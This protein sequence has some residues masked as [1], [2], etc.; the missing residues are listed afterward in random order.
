MALNPERWLVR[1]QFMEIFVRIAQHKFFKSQTFNEAG[2]KITESESVIKLFEEQLLHHFRKHDAH[3]WRSQFLWNKECDLVLK[4]HMKTIKR[5]FTKFSG[6]FSKPGKPKF[7][8]IDEFQTMI[9]N[10]G[11]LASDSIG[12]GEI[13]AL[14]NVSMMTQIKELESERHTNMFMLEFI[15]A[16]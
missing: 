10:S 13:G 11:I 7:V 8:S 2:G 1:Y 4:S 6:K 3:Q 14:F 9:S 12:P 5:L 16:I 15:E